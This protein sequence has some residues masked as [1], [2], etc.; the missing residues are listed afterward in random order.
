MIGKTIAHYNITAKLG[1]GGMGDVYRARDTKLG[2]EIALKIL[3]EQFSA[4]PERRKR[5]ER[6]ARAVAALKHPNIVTIFSI[7][8]ADG[9]YFITMELVDGKTLSALIAKRPLPLESFF[10]VSIPLAD[11]VSS[12]HAQSITHRDLKP[13]NVMIEE[14]GV[15][16]VLDFGLAKLLEPAADADRAKTI[17]GTSSDTAVGKIVGTA[18]YMSPEQAEGKPIDHR[19]D[20]FSLG[21]IFYEM[22]TGE[23]PFKGDTHIST[24]SSILKDQPRHISEVNQTL[25]RHLGR[26]VNHC[27]EKDA[28]KR[29]QTAK[30]IRN[31]LDELKREID[32]GELATEV[33]GIST[34]SRDASGAGGPATRESAPPPQRPTSRRW[35]AW[36]AAGV[37]VVGLALAVMWWSGSGNNAADNR[38]IA[39]PGE[40]PKSDARQAAVVFPFENL[41]PA[42]DAYFAA[43]VSEEITSR[44]S[45]VS[46]L[47]VISRT[48]AVQY[49]RSGKTMKDI[50]KD[51]GV[52]FVLEGSVRW[53]RAA[54]GSGRV[55]ITPQLIRV[56]DDSHLWSET[57]DR[58]VKDIFEVQTDIAGRVIDQLGVTLLGNERALME[59]KPTD[60]L[61][62]YQAYLQ[63]TNVPASNAEL[64]DVRIVGLLDRATQ[65]DPKFLAAWYKLA[66]HH[67]N[68][69]RNFDRT[70]ERLAR[71]RGAIQ[72][73]EAV[74]PQ[75]PITRLARGYYYYYG[76]SDYDRALEEFV[77]ASEARPNDS[78]A[79]AAMAYIYRR[80][81][82]L[83]EMIDH[84]KRAQALDP[85]NAEI[86]RNMAATYGARRQFEETL[87]SL[88]Q[89]IALDPDDFELRFIRAGTYFSW[90]GD[91]KTAAE[92]LKEPPAG[93]L[94]QYRV[95]WYWMHFLQRDYAR[96]LEV[97]GP[98]DESVPYV[99]IVKSQ[100]I[101]VA[102]THWHGDKAARSRLEPAAQILEE[103]LQISPSNAGNRASLSIIYAYL[104]RETDAVHQ[105]KLA[106]DLTA[107]DNFNGPAQVQNLAQVYAI[108]G[109]HDEAI[110]L[111]ERL[112]VMSYEDPI[113]VH[114]LRLDPSWDPLRDHPRFKELVK[115][116]GRV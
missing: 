70:E 39:S 38:S 16:K 51:L 11:A 55:R 61:E 65:L 7:E 77:A 86:P 54:D 69:Y 98:L 19:S 22:A 25:P 13:T 18:A 113:T 105:A 72:G 20:I 110:D 1:S 91:M 37:G 99:R 84:L 62:A 73:A 17:A 42:E 36:G 100:L 90:K 82:K 35:L 43:G 106:V 41:G 49:D 64:H 29:F 24:I 95:T 63:A 8:E 104:G 83:D 60:N 85:R 26:I 57:Y 14:S 33:S 47:R 93:D 114:R 116:P 102:E 67:A 21:I 88:D 107:K 15:L 97:I 5:F 12:A 108:L 115:D 96:A 89:A 80:Q 58:E 79:L 76:F 71:S 103:A 68:L 10:D 9:R 50:G 27:L 81:G 32:S 23:R 59:D 46:G 53:A 30:D 6:E 101:A 31:E 56:A 3:P 112:L 45:A 78:E 28:D 75:H 52:D 74:D 66:R 92:M 111:L 109:R 2:R 34:R 87:R 4:D 94:T 44:L 40:S 48:S